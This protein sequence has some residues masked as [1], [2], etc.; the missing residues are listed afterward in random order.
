MK[1]LYYL[2]SDVSEMFYS[3]PDK[4]LFSLLYSMLHWYVYLHFTS[5]INKVNTVQI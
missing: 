2:F 4:S 1:D 3:V 5:L